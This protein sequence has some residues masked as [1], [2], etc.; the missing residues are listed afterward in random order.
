[1]QQVKTSAV[2]PPL[3]RLLMI[4]Y[5]FPHLTHA[6]VALPLALFIP[7]Y[8]ADE[9]ALPMASVGLAIAASRLL[10]IISDPIV[11]ILSDRMQTR[12]G[13]RKPWLGF[14]TPLLILSAWMVFVPG[15]SIS[16]TYLFGWISLLYWLIPLSI[17]PI[18][19]GEQS[20]QPIIPS[21]RA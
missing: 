20:F 10:D 2:K 13:R 17:C 1:M 12:W 5:G 4:F 7:S 3:S 9:L 16:V 18:K 11:G 6:I 8:Y 15:E 21:A 19:H 14:G